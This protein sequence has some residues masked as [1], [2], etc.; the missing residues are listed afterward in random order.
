MVSGAENDPTQGPAGRGRAP[1]VEKL[2]SALV[3]GVG[4]RLTSQVIG[5]SLV[6]F[7]SRYLDLTE[8]GIYSLAWAATVI[9]VS[10]IFTGFYQSILRSRDLDDEVDTMFWLMFAVGACGTATMLIISGFVSP[11]L[12][13]AMRALSVIPTVVVL[14]AWNEAQLLAAGKAR[15]ASI[16]HAVSEVVGIVVVVLTLNAGFGLMGLVLGRLAATLSGL[17][18]TTAMVRRRPRL[19][20][21]AAASVRA[22]RTAL[23][24]WASAGVGMFANYGSDIILGLFL[25]PAAVGAYRGGSRIA[26]T[27]SDIVS[28]PLQ[29]LNW[30]KFSRLER[31]GE[32]NALRHAW[33][34]HAAFSAALTW[35]VLVSVMLLAPQLTDVL[36]GEKWRAAAPVISLLAGAKALG[37]FQQLL[38]PTLISLGRGALQVKVQGVSAALLL[39]LLLIAGPHGASAVAS[40]HIV[41]NLV[42]AGVSLWAM[43]STLGTPLR[44]A[45]PAFGPGAVVTLI[46][47]GAILGSA[48]LLTPI[49]TPGGLTAMIGGLAALWAVTIA[50]MLRARILELPTP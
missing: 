29:M 20:F 48:Q 36:F 49:T 44:K 24:L 50:L 8:F 39:V 42:M 22:F 45:L 46:C 32:L 9:A 17:S 25:S 27:A 10:F 47:A 5:F 37:M 16:H 30:A 34:H 4:S 2:F 40:A 15:S 21:G 1:L 41:V 14:V 7:A 23:P 28:Q 31:G 12:S 19:R 33:G 26:T 11:A 13:G 18:L 43:T 38:A 6:V 35:P 3:V